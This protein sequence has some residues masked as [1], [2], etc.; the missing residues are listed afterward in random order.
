MVAITNNPA[1]QGEVSDFEFSSN[2][3]PAE[4]KRASIVQIS[5]Q[6]SDVYPYMTI[7]EAQRI[8]LSICLDIKAAIG[9]SFDTISFIAMMFPLLYVFTR[10]TGQVALQL[11]CYK[12]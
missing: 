9:S 5:R 11:V 4:E 8:N 12:D 1:L 10:H 2:L 6:M 7:A 3:N